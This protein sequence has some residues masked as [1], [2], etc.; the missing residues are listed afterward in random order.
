MSLIVSANYRDRSQKNWLVRSAQSSIDNYELHDRVVVKNFQFC[1]S[2]SGEDGFG[3]SIVAVGEPG[4]GLEIDPNK[5]VKLRFNGW[6]F[7]IESN[8]VGVHEGA[9]L[10]LDETGIYFIPA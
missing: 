6:H 8:G 7:E 2:L 1:K 3:C 9:A 10:V 4:D 5:L